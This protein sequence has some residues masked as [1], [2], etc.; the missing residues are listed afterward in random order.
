MMTLW[1]ALCPAVAMAHQAPPKVEPSKDPCGDP[2]AENQA[3]LT[4]KGEVLKVLSGDTLL[5]QF[6]NAGRRY[7]HLPGLAA[8][9]RGEPGFEASREGLAAL[10]S[11]K[12]KIE[13]FVPGSELP[14]SQSFTAMAGSFDW[15]ERQLARGLGRFV[16]VQRCEMGAYNECRCKL[17]E[18][19]AQAQRVGI[20]FSARP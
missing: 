20:W 19:K 17:A 14:K 12:T 15:S 7:V 11:G 9:K 4:F 18:Q 8:P 16:P 1:I 6:P 2:M 5:V 10:V 3:Y 13:V